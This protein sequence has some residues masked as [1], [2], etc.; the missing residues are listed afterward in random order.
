MNISEVKVLPVK[1]DAKLKAYVSI[2]IE[3]SLD[4]KGYEDHRWRAS[5]LVCGNAGEEDEGRHI[6]GPG[7]SA[8]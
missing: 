2:K 8:R 1:G 5:G 7:A 3:D 4:N 6:L